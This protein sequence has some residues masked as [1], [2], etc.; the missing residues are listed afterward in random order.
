MYIRIVQDTWLNKIRDRHNLWLTIVLFGLCAFAI[1]YLFPREARF[2]YEFEAG[3]SWVHEDLT[4]P[5][6][7]AIRKSSQELDSIKQTLV[8][9][10]PPVYV[11][12]PQVIGLSKRKFKEYI[13]SNWSESAK[14]DAGAGAIGGIFIGDRKDSINQTNH[15][16]VADNVLG[17]LYDR[18]VVYLQPEHKGIQKLNLMTDNVAV[19]RDVNRILLYEDALE[20]GKRALRKAAGIDDD[21]LYKGLESVI[22]PNY[23]FDSQ[24]TQILLTQT[25]SEISEFK[26]KVSQGDVVIR[27]GELIS[28]QKF[29]VLN[30]LKESYEKQLGGQESL[31]I[32]LLGQALLVVLCL[33]ALALFLSMFYP[34]ALALP[35]RVL[36]LLV[37]TLLVTVMVKFAL[38]ID[39]LHVYLA[40]VCILPI[41]VRAF[42]DAR[43]ALFMHVVVVFIV[44][45][46]IPNPFEFVFLQV[47]A[48]ILLLY[49]I[50]NLRSRSQFFNSA[51]V[52]FT[53]YALTYFGLNILQEGSLQ[54]IDW[55]I[56][57]W[58][59]GN[60]LLSLM[61]YPLIYLFEKSFG[62]LS[63]VSLLELADSNNSLLRE[64]NEKAPGT[65]QHSLQVGNLAEEAIRAIG[66]DALLVRAG[67]LYHDIGK[68]V[69][70]E[71][72]IEN[73]QSGMN[74]HD[75]L[76]P[77]ESAEIIINHVIGGIEIARKNNLPDAILDF[78][79]THHGTTRT[80]YFYRVAKEANPDI[81]PEIFTYP[82][83][84]PFN[85]ETA[86]LMMADAVEA[87]SRSV[88]E[89]THE[90]LQ[91]LID[92]IIDHQ[93]SMEQFSNS[94]L[95]FRNI[96]EVK[97]IFLRKLMNIYH[98]R[99][100]YPDA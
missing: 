3:K 9:Q 68:M 26:G 53:S 89:P 87:A 76:E 28:N 74:P 20:E 65:F 45:F 84:K 37:L 86:V 59:G 71:F 49:G 51:F 91:K 62:F 57:A 23:L 2:K 93:I 98:V 21:F 33:L 24:K 29:L 31:L 46:I 88:S 43:M 22:E 70:P 4:A 19:V 95:T 96:D 73:Q 100:E 79:R 85:K 97:E 38:E 81:D 8:D 18:G 1:V 99:I 61:A 17:D 15:L 80:E 16:D 41:I 64:L 66:G 90:K 75:D 77:E 39:I 67:A 5:F 36:F 50:R 92:G 32:V 78:I 69:Q 58:F 35:S 54:A 11:L 56:Y 14:S 25:Q 42:Y 12:N 82:G 52:I 27:R 30:S 48:G 72:F 60:A 34:E 6:D 55:T 13:I 83:P 7:F 10:T 40:P 44:S 94:N 63:E 47:F